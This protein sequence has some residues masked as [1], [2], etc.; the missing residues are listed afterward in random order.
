MEPQAQAMQ[1]SYN[2]WKWPQQD[3][4]FVYVQCD[5]LDSTNPSVTAQHVL[6]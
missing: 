1:K 6:E 4:L 2:R 3:H 5:Q